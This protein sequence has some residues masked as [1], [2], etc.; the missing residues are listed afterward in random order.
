M[1]YT[2]LAVMSEYER[3]LSSLIKRGCRVNSRIPAGVSRDS[4]E[5]GRWKWIVGEGFQGKEYDV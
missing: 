4:R 3:L 1:Q 2:S 5:G